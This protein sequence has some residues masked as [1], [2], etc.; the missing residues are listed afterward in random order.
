MS[1]ALIDRIESRLSAL[2]KTAEG[3]SKDAGLGR[4]FIRTI[5][6]RPETSPRGDNLAALA[7]ALQCS[8]DYL[9]GLTELIGSPPEGGVGEVVLPIRGEVGAGAW[10]AVD[11]LPQEPLGWAPAQAIPAYAAWPQWL[12]AVRG[13]SYNR[14]IPDGSTVHVVDAIAMGY[15]P[16]HDD[17]VIVERSRA[18]GSFLQRTI[19][20]V[21]LTPEGIE[22]W[23]RSYNPKWAAPL[24][25]SDGLAEGED[26]T[27]EIVGKVL[28]AYLTL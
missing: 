17:V 24:I 16:R 3:A 26:A 4:D 1:R 14:F 19:K 28:R 21:A 12:E 10:L 18:Q 2:G 27:V 23:P 11:D 20:Q 15:T 6:R 13:D 22:L 25:L 8:V 9:L 7:G 5:Q